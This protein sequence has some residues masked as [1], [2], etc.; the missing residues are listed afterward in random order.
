MVFAFFGISRGITQILARNL[1]CD[2]GDRIVIGL[3]GY[4]VVG[5]VLNFFGLINPQTI[6]ILLF[7]GFFLQVRHVLSI[8]PKFFE[9]FYSLSLS[10]KLRYLLYFAFAIGF[11]GVGI[12]RQNWNYGDDGEAYFAFAKK[13]LA[14]GGLYAEPFSERRMLGG[15]GASTFLDSSVVAF[16]TFNYIRLADFGIGAA[17]YFYIIWNLKNRQRKKLASLFMIAPLLLPFPVV[18]ISSLYT[19]AAL[20]L[21]LMT[22]L[23]D[24]ETASSYTNLKIILPMTSLV[25]LKN[26]NLVFVVLLMIIFCVKESG[27]IRSKC[28]FIFTPIYSVIRLSLAVSGLSLAWLLSL[29][30]DPKN[31]SKFYSF[32]YF[33]T[34]SRDYQFTFVGSISP[35]I[36]TLAY[37]LIYSPYIQAFLIISVL[38][39]CSSDFMKTKFPLILLSLMAAFFIGNVSIFLLTDGYGLDRYCFAFGVSLLQISLY[40]IDRYFN[41][42]RMLLV[43]F[44][45]ANLITYQSILK[46]DVVYTVKTL[47]KKLKP[48]PYG[49][50][51]CL[52]YLKL[53]KLQSLVPPRESILVSTT[54]NCSFDY[55]RNQILIN[56]FPGMISPSPGIPLLRGSSDLQLY[57]YRAG[58]QFVIV[59]YPNQESKKYLEELSNGQINSRWLTQQGTLKLAYFDLFRTLR[60]IGTVS[61]GSQ[62]FELFRIELQT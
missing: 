61:I 16:L 24:E 51:P 55:V 36:N 41:H 11:I 6:F 17:M 33:Q 3:S 42:T 59:E 62:N 29:L 25:C 38:L 35:S 57:L 26:S 2:S 12:T 30:Q 13:M 32:N 20:F 9:K 23:F 15:L 21:Y 52:Q 43:F 53:E 22:L 27:K 49:S 4:L 45:T 37:E 31:L 50:N 39:I 44:L 46:F 58:V 14:Q 48:E 54:K 7:L 34:S 47:A 60:P 5:G 1:V 56:D 8:F 10:F 18:N 28:W 40:L 19:S